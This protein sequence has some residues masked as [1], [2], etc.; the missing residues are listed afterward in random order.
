MLSEEI[1]HLENARCS[2][3]VSS[4]LLVLDKSLEILDRARTSKY[5]LRKCQIAEMTG[6]PL[7]Y[8]PNM[9]LAVPSTSIRETRQG[10]FNWHAEL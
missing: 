2:D 3:I 1:C 8:Y 10:N 4:L 9:L 5:I 7:Y 6:K